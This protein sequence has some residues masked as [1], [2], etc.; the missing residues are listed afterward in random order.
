[1][2]TMAAKTSGPRIPRPFTPKNAKTRT[3]ADHAGKERS[4][5]RLCTALHHTDH[6]RQ[7][8]EMRR[9]GHVV[10]ER[11]DDGIDC[12][13]GEDRDLRADA[14]GDHPEEKREGYADEL[15]DEQRRDHRVLVDPDLTAERRCHPD[16]GLDAVVVDQERDEQQER[17]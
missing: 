2:S 3:A 12:E 5:E 1:M 10:P 8:V 16:D 11:D 13:A 4:A 15:R 6:D 14:S 17:L 9:A 7:R